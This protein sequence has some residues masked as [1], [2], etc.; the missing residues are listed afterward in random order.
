MWSR[1]R[2]STR[3]RVRGVTLTELLVALV[4]SSLAALAIYGAFTG[5]SSVT[6][7]T[8]AQDN[9]WQQARTAMTMLTQAIEEAGY[10]LPMNEC[11]SGIHANVPSTTTST[12]TV[13][14]TVSTSSPSGGL[15]LNPVAAAPQTSASPYF[16][17]P[18]S[19]NTY[20]L[21]TVAG[22]SVF[23]AA[24]V[25]TITKTS[26]TSVTSVNF[27]V[28]NASLLQPMDMFLIPLPNSSCIMGQITNS[29]PAQGSNVVANHGLSAF[30]ASGGFSATDPGITA[31]QL[32]NRGVINLGN[33]GFT[34]KN[35]FIL[36]SGGSQVPSLYMQAYTYLNGAG[37]GTP[38]PVLL[39]A[40]GIVDMQLAFGYGKNGVVSQYVLP[41]ATP[42]AGMTSSD[43][44]T[45]QLALLVRSTRTAPGHYSGNPPSKVVVS[46]NINPA[47]PSAIY[48]IPTNLPPGK[49]MGCVAG[50]CNHYLYRVFTTV[51]PVRNDIWGQ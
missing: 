19:V 41:G 11:G 29:N 47:I 40:R 2:S 46:G 17:T 3:S 23:G 37:G 39:V 24:P 10:G 33:T 28:S 1:Q 35:F 5:L 49:T 21:T 14:Y 38:G 16:Y 31:S 15:F 26:G 25:T 43:L 13:Q 27:F 32:I 22:G 30:N 12:S 7:Q 9:A 45:V 6:T 8:R 51:I 48:Q 18:G 20:A 36:D 42:P 34:I 4:I 44:L 50:D